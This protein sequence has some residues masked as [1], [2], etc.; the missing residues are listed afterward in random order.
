VP[1][2][3][4][5]AGWLLLLLAFVVTIVGLI[6]VV[7]LFGPWLAIVGVMLLIGIVLGVAGPGGLWGRIIGVILIVAAIILLVLALDATLPAL[8]IGGSNGART[9]IG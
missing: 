5:G 7:W 4:R 1:M 8:V 6:V 2:N 3:E 9:R